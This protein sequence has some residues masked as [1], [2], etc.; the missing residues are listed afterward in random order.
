MSKV[1][2]VIIE[3]NPG[4]VDL[5][6]QPDPLFGMIDHAAPMWFDGGDGFCAGGNFGPFTQ[7][8]AHFVFEVIPFA[9]S[10]DR[11]DQR[12]MVGA[13]IVS[14]FSSLFKAFEDFLL[15]GLGTG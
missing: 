7:V 3:A 1:A 5:F 2:V 13:Q 14:Q 4:A 12:G 11:F 6:D 8:V 9:T 15:T 10:G